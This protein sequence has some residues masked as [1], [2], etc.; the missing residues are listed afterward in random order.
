MQSQ[1]A[2]DLSGKLGGLRVRENG[3]YRHRARHNLLNWGNPRFPTWWFDPFDNMLNKVQYVA[4]ASNKLKTFEVLSQ[5]AFP[6]LPEWHTELDVATSFLANPK[7][8]DRINAVLCRTQLNAMSGHGIVMAKTVPELVRAPLY[9]RYVPK[10]WEFRIHVFLGEV[11]DAVEKRKRATVAIGN[12]YIRSHDYG[13][14][15]C[16]EDI[17]VPDVCVQAALM[18]V[19]T[20]QLDFGA[21]DIGY[22]EEFGTILYEVNTAPGLEGTTLENYAKKISTLY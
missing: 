21:V 17:H 5:N 9:V 20:L 4:N 15:F 16:R 1:S 12:K 3:R 11:I 19:S 22:H 14:V 18:A 10:Q 13:W 8:P 7:Y 6:F 2:K